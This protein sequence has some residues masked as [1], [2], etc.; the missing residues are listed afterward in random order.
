MIKFKRGDT[1]ILPKNVM[2]QDKEAG[3]LCFT[4]LM[5]GLQ[6]ADTLRG[7]LKSGHMSP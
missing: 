7:W 5:T 6:G 3:M 1:F 4:G 2:W